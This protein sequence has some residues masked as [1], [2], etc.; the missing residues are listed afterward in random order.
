LRLFAGISIVLRKPNKQQ[1]VRDMEEKKEL[2]A[3]PSVPKKSGGAGKKILIIGLPL[4]IIQLVAVYFI[5]ANILLNRLQLNNAAP[6]AVQAGKEHS[7]NGEN[8]D[9][10]VELGKFIYSID[11]IIL[12][13]AGTE[14]KKFFMMSIAFDLSSEKDK[15]TFE[16]KQIMI[17]DAVIS[18]AS[19]KNLTQLN[20]IAYRDTLRS[21]IVKEISKIINDIKINRVYF[22]KFIIN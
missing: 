14:G 19:A 17:K 3:A 2:E 10:K 12:N 1:N 21:D 8:K 22:S 7:E 16:E 9:S 20:N 13:P 5:T 4:F 11:D 15:K 18:T 6:A